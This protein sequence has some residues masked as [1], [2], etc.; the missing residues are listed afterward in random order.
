MHVGEVNYI[1]N[2]HRISTLM[3]VDTT[4]PLW[5]LFDIY[6]AVQKVKLLGRLCSFITVAILDT[7]C[8][9]RLLY[10]IHRYYDSKIYTLWFSYKIAA[11][12][13]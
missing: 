3:H 6:G 1:R 9:L 7:Y 5:A 10:R 13:D 2:G 11:S 8:V 4:L 12:F